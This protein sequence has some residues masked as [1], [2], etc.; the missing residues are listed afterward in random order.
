MKEIITHTITLMYSYKSQD[1]VMQ[2][3]VL[4]IFLWKPYVH[5]NKTTNWHGTE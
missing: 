1:G 3:M 2:G 4:K 5:H